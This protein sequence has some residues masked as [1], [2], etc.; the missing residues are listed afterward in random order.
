[1]LIIIIQFLLILVSIAF[2]TL[3]ERKLISNFQFRVGPNF[4]F[5]IQPL[6]D[7]I[8]LFLKNILFNN[9]SDFLIYLVS[10]FAM[11]F[12]S[13]IYFL[14][15]PIPFINLSWFDMY[16]G[17]F[18]LITIGCLSI[19]PII[20][21]GWSSF[22]NFAI[23]GSI[24]G[25]IQSLSYEILIPFILFI[26]GIISCS[27]NFFD[28]LSLQVFNWNLFILVL[29]FPFLF[30]IVLM[31]TNRIPFDLPESESELVS[32]YNVEY[33]SI[34][35]VLFFL[36]EY[37]HLIIHCF[38]LSSLFFNGLVLLSLFILYLFII[39]RSSFCRIRW[40]DI[41]LFTWRELLIFVLIL[42]MFYF[43]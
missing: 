33:S 15:I 21:G 19:Y 37:L 28:I 31:E 6:F 4:L 40:F 17:L 7:G 27:F 38:I 10:S 22:N 26:F 36:G 1:L 3:F 35:F 12:L 30:I 14:F 16:F 9:K 5:F 42:S 8:K 18:W 24:R 43:S 11:L 23:L 29:V 39:I 2:L 41:I 32:G 34:L 25:I 20:W 13:L